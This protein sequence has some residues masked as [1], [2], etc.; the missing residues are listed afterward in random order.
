MNNTSQ[1]NL[2]KQLLDQELPLT[3]EQYLAYRQRVSDGIRK[4]QREETIM[5]IVTK[6]AW[7]LTAVVFLI[8]GILDFN[9][10]RVPGSPGDLVRLS[11]IFPTLICLA[12]ST[13]LLAV[14]LI[15]YRP[16]LKNAEHEAMLLS[17]QRQLHELRSQLPK[18]SN[19]APTAQ[20]KNASP[21][22]N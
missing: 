11:L 13:A 18:D 6:S 21:T 19:R 12:C 3:D 1:R 4:V 22:S 7:A 14:Y 16:R 5:R 8:V 9:L 15:N 10:E 17:L 2:M 20:G